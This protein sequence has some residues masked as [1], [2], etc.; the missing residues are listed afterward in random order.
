[1]SSRCQFARYACLGR[2]III[3]FKDWKLNYKRNLNIIFL[4]IKPVWIAI[5]HNKVTLIWKPTFKNEKGKLLLF[6]TNTHQHAYN[7]TFEG[8]Q[9]GVIIILKLDDC[10]PS[11]YISWSRPR[12]ALTSGKL[13]ILQS[14]LQ[15]YIPNP[16]YTIVQESKMYV[17]CSS[18]QAWDMRITQPKVWS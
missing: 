11:S 18:T 5:L 1:M 15:A 12:V 2:P 13:R 9:S 14:N 6:C 8:Q 4:L 17:C 3:V 10:T 7:I 16:T